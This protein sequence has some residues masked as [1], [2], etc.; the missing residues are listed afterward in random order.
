MDFQSFCSVPA[1]LVETVRGPVR[2]C[3]EGDVEVFKGI[4]YGRAGRFRAPEP[5]P[6]WKEPLDAT[7]Y[8]CVCP[9]L[10]MEKPGGELLVPHRYWVQNEDCLNLNVW[11]PG[12][13]GKRPVLVWLHGGGYFAGSSIEQ[14]AYE[15]GNMA[16]LGDC[17]VVSIN[18]RLNILGYFDLSEFGAAYENSGNAG[19]DDIVLAL[20][21][22]RENIAA[23]GGDPDNVTVFGQSGGGAKVTTLLQTP[24]ADGLYHR[25]VVMSGVIGP[26]LADSAGSARECAEAMMAELNVSG[27]DGLERVSYAQLAAAY[28][29][30]SP[31]LKAQG[32]PVGCTPSP[33]RFYLGDPLVSAAGFR[34]ETV[35]IPLMVGTVYAEFLG[36]MN[37][38]SVTVEELFSPEEREELLP[39]FRAAYP[40]RP[41]GDL[42]ALDTIFRSPTIRYIKARAARGGRVF[43]YLFQQDFPINGGSK[44][45]HCADIPFFFHNRELVPVCCFPGAAALEER[46]F[47]ALLS[48]ARIGRPQADGEDGWSESTPEKEYTYLFGPDCRQE[49]NFDHRLI[50]AWEPL[51]AEMME[52]MT[53]SGAQ[54]QH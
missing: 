1:P 39:L 20:R 27:V 18:H 2:G 26:L 11:T 35:N 43:S 4:P 32:K 31:A 29:K 51:S 30:V 53:R 47:R 34:E 38:T 25:G 12:S 19:G 44:A 40:G 14:V 42:L 5:V 6:A 7:S 45:W 24:A 28:N 52:R 49:V 15:G 13:Q 41:D 33:N 9:L 17:V 46:V 21:W 22:V 8:G 36:F 23:F 48:F 10:S 37:S 50:R 16:R 3:R 54:I